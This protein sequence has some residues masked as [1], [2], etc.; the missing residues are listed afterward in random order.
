MGSAVLFGL[1]P[2][3]QISRLVGVTRGAASK[4]IRLELRSALV[5]VQVALAFVL[6]AGTGL[7]IRSLDKLGTIERG[8]APTVKR[9]IMP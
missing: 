3:A 5:I 7:F 9:R 6:L 8:L 4:G 1:A 2:F